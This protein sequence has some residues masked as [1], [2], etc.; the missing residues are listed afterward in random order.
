MLQAAGCCSKV[1][2]EEMQRSPDCTD[3]YNV[4]HVP[5]RLFMNYSMGSAQNMADLAQCDMEVSKQALRWALIWRLQMHLL[6]HPVC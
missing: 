1:S 2:G 3:V 5:C 4:A 6:L